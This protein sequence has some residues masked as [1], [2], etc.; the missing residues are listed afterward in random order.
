MPDFNITLDVIPNL[1]KIRLHTVSILVV[2]N[3]QEL[4]QLRT[5]LRD[6]IM[7]IGVEE[8]LLKQVVILVEHA[9][10]N[11]HVALEGGAR[12]ILVLHDGG[13]DE[14]AHEGDAE[15][16]RHRLVVLLEGVLVDVQPQTLIEVLEEDA[17]HV[18]ALADDDGV[19]LRELL[20]VGEGGAEHGVRRDVAHA[21]LL[22][23]L[24]EV[25]LHRGD[26]ADDALLRQVWNN[27]LEDG[28]GVLQRHGVDEQL[29]AE[30]LYL[31]VG[32]EAL[33]VVGEPHALGVALKHGH[34]VVETQ[35]VD[36]EAPHLACSHN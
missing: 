31:F 34:L 10:G 3:L 30:R 27:L 21:R 2:D 20:Q 9:L 35:Q 12:C 15:R 32:G 33:A 5:D 24:P 11:A 18:V 8:Y 14:G 4:F 36:E 22:V 6:L 13:K 29:G 25:G 23:E 16:I 19:L 1:G 28:D 17:P 7:S 26:V